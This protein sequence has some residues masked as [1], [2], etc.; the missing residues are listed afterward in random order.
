MDDLTRARI[1][2]LL[3]S[4]PGLRALVI[5]DLILDR[6]VTGTADR[7][8]PEGP[9]PVVRVERDECVPGG[10]A[11]VAANLVALGA[12]AAIVGCVGDDAAGVTLRGLLD[13]RGVD[14]RHLVVERER[15]TTVKT[16]VVARG[17][18]I[19]R[20]DSEDDEDVDAAL[21]GRIVAE[22]S[23]AVDGCDVV[24]LQ[25]YDKGVLAE[26]VVRA[27]LD[28]ATGLGL[29]IVVDPKRRHFFAYAGATLFK[30]NA[31]E[32]SEA[33]GEPLRPGDPTWMRQARARIACD[34][35]LVTLG[36]HGML[37]CEEA[38][39]LTHLSGAARAVFDVSGAGDT[40]TAVCGILLAAGASAF[41]AAW[42]ANHAAAVEV[43]KRGVATVSIEELRRQIAE[44]APL[45]EV[46]PDA[47]R[48][49]RNLAATHPN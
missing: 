24:I 36:P 20:F 41:E 37:L 1:D 4:I 47:P 32:L 12:S 5:G 43:G 13:D 21:A 49:D 38:E 29:P 44:H 18:Q 27:S 7:V 34:A 30:P 8:S 39:S 28:L 16:R 26:P 22:A 40:V 11:N 6:Y 17:Q 31:R 19:V 10:A 25:D 14:A 2:E 42:I 9:V 48:P 45:T 15:R 46:A 35:L 3:D 23:R 33:L